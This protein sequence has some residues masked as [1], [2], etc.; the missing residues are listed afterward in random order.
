LPRG[1]APVDEH[2]RS[3]A[4]AFSFASTPR[5]DDGRDAQAGAVVARIRVDERVEI[6]KAAVDAPA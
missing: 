3:L 1:S 4:R 5:H 2:Q 6:P